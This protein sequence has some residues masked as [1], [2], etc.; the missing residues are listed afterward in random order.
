MLAAYGHQ[1]A[2]FELVVDALQPQRDLSRTPVF[3]VLFDLLNSPKPR[4]TLPGL[5]L[6]VQEAETGAS[7]FDLTVQMEDT[8]AGLTAVIEYNTDLF[9]RSTIERMMAHFQVL[10]SGA[11]ASPEQRLRELPLLAAEERRRLLVEW[12]ATHLRRPE[13]VRL[14]QWVEAQVERTPE[15]VSVVYGGQSLRYR[16]LEARANQLARYL[17]RMGVGPESRV[18][19]FMERSVE[20]VV[21]LLGVLKA[22]GAYVPLDP[23]YPRERVEYLVM[24]AQ[25]EVVLSQQHLEALLPPSGARRVLLDTQWEEIAREE[26]GRV[27]GSAGGEQPRVR[28]LHVRLDGPAQGRDEHARGDLQ[29]AAVDAGRVWAERR[30][31]GCCR[32]RRSASTCRCGSSSG[33]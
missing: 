5:E 3:Q 24:D 6:S 10:L 8:E 14:H 2:P 29:P 33:R 9:D 13:G 15:A 27:G 26:A 21:G 11:V 20:L 30:M 7:K 12:N 18:G 17:R 25:V 19:L 23:G 4:L 28:D 16:E 1:D 31:T 32:R 22:G